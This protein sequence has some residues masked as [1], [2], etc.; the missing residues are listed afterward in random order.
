LIKLVIA[1]QGSD[2]VH[3]LWSGKYRGASSVLA[4]A[5]GRAA[6]ASARRSDRL[7]QRTYAEAVESFDQGYEELVAI[8]ADEQL[9]RT[10]GAL[11]AEFAL[12]GYDSVHLATALS[13]AEHEIALVSWDHDLCDAALQAGLTVLGG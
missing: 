8:G 12:R 3:E 4:Y 11:A 6:L 2:L 5:E 7:T 9:T 13:L 10:A 1:E